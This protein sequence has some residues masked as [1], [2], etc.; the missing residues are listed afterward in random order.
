MNKKSALQA[1]VNT[2]RH[3]YMHDL[4]EHRILVKHHKAKLRLTLNARST[5]EHVL[6]FKLSHHHSPCDA[7]HVLCTARTRNTFTQR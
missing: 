2:Q 5:E 7:L 3:K 6:G 1:E 4:L